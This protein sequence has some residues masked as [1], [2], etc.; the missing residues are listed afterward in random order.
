MKTLLLLALLLAPAVAHAAPAVV[1]VYHADA[2]PGAKGVSRYLTYVRPTSGGLFLVSSSARPDTRFLHGDPVDAVQVAAK[3]KR[4]ARWVLRPVL[5]RAA[6]GVLPAVTGALGPQPTA[7]ILVRFSDSPAT[8]WLTQ[9]AARALILDAGPGTVSSFFREASYGQTWLTGEAYGPY[10]ISIAG[11]GCPYGTIAALAD[12]AL[13]AQ[14]GAAVVAT[15]T[16]F[17]YLFP[18]S[19]CGWAGL[20]TVGGTPSRA[21]LNG[22]GSAGLVAHELGHNLGLYHAHRLTCPAPAS[23]GTIPPCSSVEYGDAYS[24]M[25]YADPKHPA[26]PEKQVLGWLG[27]GASPPL[28]TVEANG[29]YPLE[30]YQAPGTGAKALRVRTANGDWVY[31]EARKAWGRDNLDPNPIGRDLNAIG[32]VLVH[33]WRGYPGGDGIYLVTASAPFDYAVV[34]GKPLTVGGVTVTVASV[35]AAGAE[36]RI[37]G[38]AGPVDPPPPPCPPTCDPPPVG[39]AVSVTTTF[40]Y[41]NTGKAQLFVVDVPPYQCRRRTGGTSLLEVSKGGALLGKAVPVPNPSPKGETFT[42]RCAVDGTTA[43]LYLAGA[44]KVSVAK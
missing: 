35:S 30:P 11:G 41:K 20:G 16:R 28:T 10:T 40:A 12:Q 8:P 6:A 23:V 4:G 2:A 26:A 27:F 19:G 21:W 24:V 18:N 36:V 14:V 44:L 29:T 42:L 33:L 25:G 22:G 34:P 7:V 1:E 39:G 43:K 15:Y 3:G 31:L 9:A 17:V 32:G 13:Q 38:I 37:S 5:R